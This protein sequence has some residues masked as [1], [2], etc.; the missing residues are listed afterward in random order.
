MKILSNKQYELFLAQQRKLQQLQKENEQL[1]NQIKIL[2]NDKNIL[3][4][5]INPD[6]MGLD[7]PNTNERGLTGEAETPLNFSD[8]IEL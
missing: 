2:K 6:I 4:N 8:I 5:I 7:F 1:K 3:L